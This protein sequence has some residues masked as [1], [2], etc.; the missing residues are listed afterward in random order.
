VIVLT[1]NRPIVDLFV[2]FPFD[3][4]T[5]NPD[6]KGS[7]TLKPGDLC[8]ISLTPSTV[9]GRAIMRL[10]GS[11]ADGSRVGTISHRTRIDSDGRSRISLVPGIGYEVFSTCYR[12]E[13]GLPPDLETHGVRIRH[14]MRW[15]LDPSATFEIHS[16][17]PGCRPGG[18]GYE[19]VYPGDAASALCQPSLW[20]KGVGQSAIPVEPDNIAHDWPVS[21]HP[22]CFEALG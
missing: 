13:R 1:K 17:A 6:S 7:V 21:S 19:M 12:R 20:V 10:E 8:K 4:T 16:C 15:D 5:E 3:V 9:P 2:G 18:T 11:N 22:R 14:S